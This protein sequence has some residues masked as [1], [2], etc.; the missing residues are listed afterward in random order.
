MKNVRQPRLKLPALLGLGLALLCPATSRADVLGDWN[1][2]AL[3]AVR[4]TD[5]TSAESTRNFAILY[6]AIY[7]AVE[8]IAGDYELFTSA[9]YS[10][11]SGTAPAGAS[12]EAAVAAAAHTI[13]TS[14][15][16]DPG[17]STGF[18][19][20]YSTQ[21]SGIADG[22]AKIDGINF[23]TLVANDIINWRTL[24]G[25]SDANDPGLYT[26]VGTVGR[27]QPTP[28]AYS[29]AAL[30]GWGDVKTFAITGPGPYQTSLGMSNADYVQTAQ[31]AAD[32]NQVQS[33]GSASSVTRTPDQLSAAYFWAGRPGTNTVAGLWNQIAQT[34][35]ENGG[36]TLQQRARVFAAMN[37]AMADSAIVT[38]ATKFD[39]DFWSPILA[40]AN[41]SADGNA[42]TIE[43]AAWAPLID[44]PN[45]PAYFSD[46]SALSAAAAQIL[47]ALMGNNNI[48]FALGSDTDGDGLADILRNFAGFLQA[49]EEAGL[50]Q[51]WAGNSYGT[52]NTDAQTAGA[53]VA[54]TVL[55]TQFALVPE[56][57]AA[58]LV[59]LGAGLMF[60][61]RCPQGG[62]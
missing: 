54:T 39:V 15:Y 57:G 25:A 17:L 22:Q 32:Y 36:L 45:L 50:S 33:L 40:I 52:G 62:R 20:L 18:T 30:P 41:G 2:Q 46:H 55:N 51:I 26:P 60:R 10:G 29:A 9:G 8:G 13:M 56:P 1:S 3:M 7:N 6:T 11:P 24:D 61:R 31:Y 58:L 21:L 59:A 27:W 28:P 5:Q 42:A 48:N 16:T 14:L 35:T 47:A 37:V 44:S 53:S 12:M 19:T 49:A 43:D 4:S 38:W 23:G 34:V